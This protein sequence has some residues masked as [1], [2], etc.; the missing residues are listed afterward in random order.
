MDSE[1][2]PQGTENKPLEDEVAS[3]PP[4]NWMATE[5]MLTFPPPALLSVTLVPLDAVETAGRFRVWLFLQDKNILL[6]DRK[7]ENGFPELK[8]LKQKLRDMV[9]P[10]RSLGHSD[11][12]KK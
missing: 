2:L 12:Q 8:I 10:E 11:T 3:I 1:D 4:A 5:L 9:D 6:W 7:T